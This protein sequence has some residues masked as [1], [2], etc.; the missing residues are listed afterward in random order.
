MNFDFRRIETE[1]ARKAIAQ[2]ERRFIR[3]PDFD[4][5]IV[6]DLHGARVRLDIAVKSQRRAKGMLENPR[7]FF[8]SGVDVAVAPIDR[9]IECWA[10]PSTRSGAFLIARRD[11]RAA[12]ARRAVSP[13]R[14]R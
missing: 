10:T 5:A 9:R 13:R 1:I 12:P 3:R 7:G 4:L 11:Y 6:M 2:R 8:E 14:G